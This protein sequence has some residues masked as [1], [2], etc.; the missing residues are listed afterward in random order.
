MN[1]GPL[2]GTA[3]PLHAITAL[4]LN[5]LPARDVAAATRLAEARH[6]QKSQTSP[7]PDLPAEARAEATLEAYYW[8]QAARSV[9]LAR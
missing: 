2:D 4:V 7:W 8:L 5:A 9:G 6:R 3:G 1:R